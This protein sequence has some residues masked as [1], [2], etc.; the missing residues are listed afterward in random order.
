M[1]A[2]A[3]LPIFTFLVRRRPL[4]AIVIITATKEEVS[5]CSM[6]NVKVRVIGRVSGSD[7]RGQMST[8]LSPV[9]HFGKWV[10]PFS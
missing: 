3:A 6:K 10:Y 7:G 8:G 2:D 5:P 9:H 4:V 1:K